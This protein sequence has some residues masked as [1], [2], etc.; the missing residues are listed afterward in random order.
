MWKMHLFWIMLFLTAIIAGHEVKE[1]ESY[2]FTSFLEEQ[3]HVLCGYQE[4]MA[5]STSDEKKRW[6]FPDERQHKTTEDDILILAQDRNCT[7][8]KNGTTVRKE[9]GEEYN[10]RNIVGQLLDSVTGNPE[11]LRVRFFYISQVCD[12][13]RDRN[14]ISEVGFAGMI[15]ILATIGFILLAAVIIPWIMKACKEAREGRYFF[16]ATNDPGV[17]SSRYS[18]LD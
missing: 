4:A 17:L 9:N 10:L 15:I 18:E 14:V 11:K 6:F 7:L 2:Q 12:E 1:V 16:D 13:K 8:M 5:E 3:P